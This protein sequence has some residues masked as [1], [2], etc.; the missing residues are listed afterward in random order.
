V[1]VYAVRMFFTMVCSGV[2]GV[3]DTVVFFVLPLVH[4]V[5]PAK[6]SPPVGGS[7]LRHAFVWQEAGGFRPTHP[8]WVAVI[9]GLVAECAKSPLIESR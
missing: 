6:S 7:R 8:A 2:A 5:L 1:T 4:R 9:R 3:S